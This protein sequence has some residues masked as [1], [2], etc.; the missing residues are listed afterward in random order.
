MQKELG[1]TYK[2]AWRLRK[3]TR[4]ELLFLDDYFREQEENSNEVDGERRMGRRIVFASIV[5]KFARRLPDSARR[6]LTRL[7]SS[8]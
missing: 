3:V 7:A 8:Q 6:G 1:I 2:A 4:A 5:R